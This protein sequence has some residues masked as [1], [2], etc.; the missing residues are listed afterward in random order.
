MTT[1]RDVVI[2]AMR[3]ELM[4]QSNAG[5]LDADN[6]VQV[7][8]DIDLGGLADAA[9]AAAAM[10]NV[11]DKIRQVMIDAGFD[12]AAI[13]EAEMERWRSWVQEWVE[14]ASP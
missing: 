7:D 8:G 2:A 9:L 3:A 6:S 12:P 13:D 11:V 10:T 14:A 5:E 4:R 1:L